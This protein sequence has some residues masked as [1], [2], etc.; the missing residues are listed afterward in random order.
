M[1]KVATAVLCVWMASCGARHVESGAVVSTENVRQETAETKAL[2]REL[3]NAGTSDARRDELVTELSARPITEVGPMAV[4]T[5]HREYEG[6]NP[7]GFD[8]APAVAKTAKPWMESQYTAEEKIR[9]AGAAIWN[10]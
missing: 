8:Y 7:G 3:W 2:F 9:T 6:A 1:R 5:M 4:Q 10:G